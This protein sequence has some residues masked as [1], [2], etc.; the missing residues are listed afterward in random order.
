M[1]VLAL[2]PA[3][4]ASSRL[5]GKPLVEIVGKSM[6]R[7]VYERVSRATG[8]DNVVVATDDQRIH[9]HVVEFGGLAVMTSSDHISGTDRIAEA[10]ASFNDAEIVVNIQG[11]EPMI[12]PTIIEALVQS[13]KDSHYGCSTPVTRIREMRDLFDTNVVKVALRRDRTPLYFSRSPIPCLRDREPEEWLATC[14]FYR[15]IGI[16]AYRREALD[17]FVTSPPSAIEVCEQLEQLRMLELGIPICCV[18]TEY[19]GHSVD[20]PEDV[21]RVERLLSTEP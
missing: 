20:T 11:D 19:E 15:H 2:I 14:P 8:V 21:M 9:S 16:Y 10:A 12:D 17:Q 13:L 7:H 1:K 5:P 6:I 3:R 4:Y 18:E